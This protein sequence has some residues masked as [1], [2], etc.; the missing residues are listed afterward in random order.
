[1][2]RAMLLASA[3]IVCVGLFSGPAGARV[4]PQTV[5]LAKVDATSLSAGYRSTK[6]VGSSVVKHATQ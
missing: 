3:V 6:V 1:M 4:T 5:E 2:K